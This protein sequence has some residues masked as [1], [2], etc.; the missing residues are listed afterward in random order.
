M[1]WI[2]AK[3]RPPKN[4]ESIFYSN[5]LCARCLGD[6]LRFRVQCDIPRGFGLGDRL[7]NGIK[8]SVGV[9]Q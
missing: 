1:A 8:K 2:R 7:S 6:P 4:K 5:L 9:I 3:A